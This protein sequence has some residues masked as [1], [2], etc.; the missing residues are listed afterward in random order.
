MVSFLA[1]PERSVT[2]PDGAEWHVALVRG[3][4]WH[5]ADWDRHPTVP[6]HP[7]ERPLLN[8]LVEGFLIDRVL[9]LVYRARRRN[10][11]RVVLR[12]TPHRPLT[13]A[14]LD[15]RYEGKDVAARRAAELLLAIRRDGFEARG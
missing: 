3:N 4:K 13:S 6:R 9:W 2:A 8:V 1:N 10:D 12:S 11:W 14:V 7:F 15:E 5:G